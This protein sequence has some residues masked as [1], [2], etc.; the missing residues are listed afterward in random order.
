MKT[1][2]R[3]ASVRMAEESQRKTIKVIDRFDK[4]LELYHIMREQQQVIKK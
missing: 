2:S 3:T 1:T 4:K